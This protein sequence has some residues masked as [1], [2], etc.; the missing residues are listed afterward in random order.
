M[1]D[2]TA[3]FPLQA[4]LVYLN[5]AG[6]GPW[7]RRTAEA[8]QH[9]ATENLHRGARDYPRWM[10][11][12]QRLREQG[13]ALL[14]A[15]SAADIGLLKNTSEA[16]SVVAYGLAW[17]PGDNVVICAHEFPS[18][19]VLWESLVC[20]G[21]D[22]R[23]AADENPSPEDAL[24]ACVDQNTRLISVSAVQYHRGLRLDLE[25]IGE[26]CR[27]RGILFCIDAIQCLGALPLDVASCHADFVMADAHK[28]LLGPEGTALFYCRAERRDDLQLFQFGWHMVEDYLNFDRRDWDIAATA[29]RFEC[30]SPNMLGIHATS[31]SLSLFEE[32]GMERVGAQ[33]LDNTAY[34]LDALEQIPGVEILSPRDPARRSGIVTFRHARVPGDEL[35]RKL[36]QREVVCAP[37]GGGVRFSPHFYTPRADLE[38]AVAIVRECV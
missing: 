2:P 25:K 35:H 20:Q 11:T 3:E 12:E 9:F 1:T 21:V 19:R 18:N 10:Q 32:V 38:Q 7:P 17:H 30:G 27:A 23:E 6:V 33:V 34:L 26:F 28:W 8:V 4:G 16:L 29:R 15:P 5:H 13:R 36:M 22:V 24:F 37:R 31:A 14:N